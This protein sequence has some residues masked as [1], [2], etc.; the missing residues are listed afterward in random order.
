MP[1]K[2]TANSCERL[3]GVFPL[4]R[5]QAQG[6]KKDQAALHS[7]TF[8]H[9]QSHVRYNR[10]SVCLLLC[11]TNEKEGGENIDWLQISTNGMFGAMDLNMLVICCL[12]PLNFLNILDM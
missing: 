10:C 2:G 11:V 3:C 12:L 6:K 8:L 4:I 7:M 9:S 5:V 1:D